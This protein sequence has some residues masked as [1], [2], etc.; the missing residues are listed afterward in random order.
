MTVAAWPVFGPQPRDELAELST[1]RLSSRPLGPAPAMAAAP[2]PGGFELVDGR[3]V[4]VRRVEGPA[5]GSGD[6]TPAWYIH[7]L[8][9]SST[10][11]TRLA[12]VLAATSPGYLVDLPGSGRSDPPPRGRYSVVDDADLIAAT[13]RSV[14]GGPVHLLGNS[15]GGMVATALAARNPSLVRSLTLISPAVPDLRL[16]R[17]RGADS[18]LAVVMVPG[19]TSAAERRLAAVDATARARGMATVC[20]GDPSVVTDEDVEVAAAD[21][22]W[23]VSLPWSV[24]STISGLQ[25]LI[26]SYLRPGRWSF[27]AAARSVGVPTLVVWGTRDKLVDARLAEPTARLFP[28][29]RLLIIAGSGHVAQMEHPELTAAAVQAL[30][31]DA[32]AATP[33]APRPNPELAV[34]TSTA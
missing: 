4:Y 17:D 6:V 16:G 29:G 5:D 26:R 7:G 20:F 34:A 33:G 12:A 14:S 19:V 31:E 15:M 1:A 24:R 18:R 11:W 22:A 28:A 8:G 2:A 10:N 13:I 32:T 23:R 27:A 9:G 3:G 25:A 30:W 21:L